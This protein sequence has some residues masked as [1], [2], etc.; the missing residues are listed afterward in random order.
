MNFKKHEFSPG[1]LTFIILGSIV[2]L[3]SLCMLIWTANYDNDLRATR[4]L[5]QG[6]DVPFLNFVSG[7]FIRDAYFTLASCLIPQVF[8]LFESLIISLKK[9]NPH[10]K[11]TSFFYRNKRKMEL[12]VGIIYSILLP[13]LGY[14]LMLADSTGFGPCFYLENYQGTTFNVVTFC[15]SMLNNWAIFWGFSY[16]VI[17]RLAPRTD[18]LAQ[19]YWRRA[20]Y[21]LM[22]T[23]LMYLVVAILKLGLQRP[24]YGQIYFGDNLEKLKVD[25]F[26]RWE[27]YMKQNEFHYGWEIPDSHTRFDNQAYINDATQNLPGEYPWWKA[28]QL[29]WFFNGTPIEGTFTKDGAFPSGHLC[30][31]LAIMVGIWTYTYPKVSTKATK[32]VRPIGWTVGVAYN[33]IMFFSLGFIYSHWMSDMVFTFTEAAFMFILAYLIIKELNKVFPKWMLKVEKRAVKR[34]G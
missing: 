30:T 25:N 19:G 6:F 11:T 14:F 21:F 4:F 8:I 2:W 16:V 27:H 29:G 18:F 13:I 10:G 12:G 3:A 1:W 26:N 15:V 22:F 5:G 34:R 17:Y 32:I 23:I 31:T 24:L 9:V 33:I 28:T 20:N 7:Y